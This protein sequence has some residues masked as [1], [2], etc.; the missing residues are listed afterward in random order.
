[1]KR[2]LILHTGG[3]LGMSGRDAPPADDPRG[4]RPTPLAPDAYAEALVSRVPELQQLAT[5]EAR[6]L[7]NLDSSDIGPDEWTALADEVAAARHHDGVVIIHGTDTMA[8]T[9]SALSFALG[10]LDRP[11]VLTGSQRPLGEVRTDARR[12]LVDAVDLATRDIPE[13]GICFDGQ[14][15]RGN[16]AT[17]GDAWSYRAFASPGCPPLARLGLDVEIG[18]HVR[19]PRAPFAVDGRFDAR[20]AVCWVV[21]GMDPKQVARAGEG[22]RGVVLA[23]FGV[24]DIPVRARAL[25]PEVRKLCDA[26]VTVLVVT[27]ARAGAVDLSL[28]ANGVALAEAGALP[29]GDLLLEAAVVKLMHALALHPADAEARRVYLLS[30]VAGERTPA[31]VA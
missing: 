25:A 24:G 27:Q 1:L 10:G 11:V 7:C 13:V 9:A 21:P 23:A 16:R 18:D 14:L 2:V 30:D 19:R 26:G 5:V 4:R 12:N 22:A 31:S 8:Y 17:K 6:I 20:V 28:Y 3:T 29:G 15:Y